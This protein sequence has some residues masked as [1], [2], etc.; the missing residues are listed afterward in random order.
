MIRTLKSMWLFWD[1]EIKTSLVCCLCVALTTSLA[2]IFRGNGFLKYI[3]IMAIITCMA[4]CMANISKIKKD[5]SDDANV[6]AV[7]VHFLMI[8]VTIVLV[9]FSIFAFPA[10]ESDSIDSYGHDDAS[11]YVIAEKQVEKQLK[12]P[13]TAKFCGIS[14]ASIT[15]NENSWSVSGWVDAQNSFGATIRNNFKV[16]I[17]FTSNN[18]YTI[19]S[20]T[21]N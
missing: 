7:L 16:K 14:E 17:T 6:M 19:D 1:K 5:G 18:E 3:A 8:A 13:S 11:V 20:C 10:Y 12:S 4:V 21:I 9:L 15:K 2:V